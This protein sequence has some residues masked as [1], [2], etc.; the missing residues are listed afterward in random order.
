MLTLAEAKREDERMS[1][2]VR[3]AKAQGLL[4]DK[5]LP[6]LTKE[7][8]ERLKESIDR[9]IKRRREGDRFEDMVYGSLFC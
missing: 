9:E 2:M 3:L 7:E 6:P 4:S 5:R 8:G 1:K